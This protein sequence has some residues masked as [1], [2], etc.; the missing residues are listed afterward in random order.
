MHE[1]GVAQTILDIVERAVAGYPGAPVRNVRIAVGALA[2][3]DDAALLF[4]FDTL[5]EETVSFGAE[6]LIERKTLTGHCRDCGR[7]FESEVLET[8]CPGCKGFSIEWDGDMDTHVLSVDI[9]D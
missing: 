7:R 9:D 5:K 2:H 6:L 1:M 3:I 4:A 8:P